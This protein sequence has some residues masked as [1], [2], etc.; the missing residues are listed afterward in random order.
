MSRLGV[1]MDS[2]RIIYDELGGTR[3]TWSRTTGAS[4]VWVTPTATP[5]RP[6][7]EP[8]SRVTEARTPGSDPGSLRTVSDRCGP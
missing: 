4:G 8:G 2:V 1:C 5:A 6:L 3:T 7:A